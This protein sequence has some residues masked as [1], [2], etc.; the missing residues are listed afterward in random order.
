MLFLQPLADASAEVRPP[1]PIADATGL[2]FERALLA[3]DDA[4]RQRELSEALTSDR[5]AASWALRLAE[6]RLGRTINRV[7]EAAEWLSSCLVAEL[8]AAV[9]S[10]RPA[11]QADEIGWRLPLLIEKLFECQRRIGDFER[12]LEHEKLESLKEL[13][14][15]ASHE[16]NNPLA[17]IAARA[18]TL[19]EDETDSDRQRKLMAIHRQAMRAHEMISDLM[20][21]ARPPKLNL[22]TCELGTIVQK[23]IGELRERAEEYG[24]ELTCVCAT[25]SIDL[26]ADET[27]LGVA[28]GAIIKNALEAVGEGGHVQVAVRCV[29]LDSAHLAEVAVF[30]DGPGISEG[31]RR[32][33]FDPFFSG[34]EA[35]R[36][37]GFGAS[38]CWRIVTDH[39]GQV[40]V[41]HAGRSGA[42]ITIQLPL[43]NDAAKHGAR[44]C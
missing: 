42:E 10:D 1:L 28:I 3:A 2:A 25:E 40:V 17:N 35:G 8:A 44:P 38:K 7:E 33:M 4:A 26:R 13:A 15:G 11:S 9:T 32:H 14:Y 21:F 16:I 30:D 22:A 19:L 34:R 37:L 18:Q 41:Q 39:G 12:K 23:V 27:Q 24:I 31:V 20:L 43:A 29:T 5:N 36:G 6:T